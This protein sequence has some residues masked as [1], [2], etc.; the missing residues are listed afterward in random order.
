MRKHIHGQMSVGTA[1][2]VGALSSAFPIHATA[3]TLGGGNPQSQ[4]WSF[5]CGDFQRGEVRARITSD[6]P[7]NTDIVMAVG[8]GSRC[9]NATVVNAVTVNA[10]SAWAGCLADNSPFSYIATFTGTNPG[11]VSYIREKRCVGGNLISP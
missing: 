7:P 11:V 1:I 8:S 6:P 5:N 4:Q 3:Y 10:W 2:L 9:K